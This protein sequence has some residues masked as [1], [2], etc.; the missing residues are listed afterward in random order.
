MFGAGAVGV[1]L[2]SALLAGGAKVSLI[3][4]PEAA[5]DLRANGIRR[6]GA[7][8]E[9]AFPPSSFEVA[10]GIDSLEA[11]PNFVLVATKSFDSEAAAE[12]LYL[13]K[14]V[15]DEAHIVLCQNGWG[16]DAT[17]A[18]R[19]PPRQVWNARVIT[20][21][22]RI[23]PHHIDIT[24]HAEPVHMGSLLGESS[25]KLTGLCDAISRGGI[26]CEPTDQIAEDLWAKLLYNGLLN[27]LGAIFE[28]AYGELAA[29][30]EARHTMAALAGEIFD[31]MEA[32]GFRTHWKSAA[33]Y[34]EDFYERLIPITAAHESSTLQ[35]LRAGKRTEIDALTGAVVKLGEEHGVP[36]PVN[37]TLLAMVRFI[38]DHRRGS[39]VR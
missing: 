30:T 4:R 24:A 15:P 25:V 34:L 12:A 6:T 39:G 2:A 17:F 35:D 32:S 8:G 13:S 28:V 10:E 31:V 14:G 18:A 33:E 22:R 1:G 3:A 20:G 38:E 27:P 5:R 23:A 11:S 21:F 9:V 7:L 29:H 37:R 26:P 36:V 19:F 16:N